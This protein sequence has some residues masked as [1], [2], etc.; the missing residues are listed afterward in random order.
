M[1]RRYF[2]YLLER[3]LSFFILP[4]D[5]AVEVEPRPSYKGVVLPEA[6]CVYRDS[7]RLEPGDL[8]I[9]DLKANPADYL[10]L[11]GNVHYENDIQV[12]LETL[13]PACSPSTRLVILY[14]SSLWKPLM[15]LATRLGLRGRAPEMNWV[16]PQDVQNLLCLAGYESVL[17]ESRVLCPVWIP[18]LSNL[19]NRWIAPLPG[20]RIFCL[21]RVSVARP[22]IDRNKAQPLPSVSIVVPARNEAGNIPSILQR[23]PAM[24]P[25]D[26]LILIE[27]HSKDE[28]WQAIQ[29]LIKTN[30]GRCIL[31]AQQ[32]GAG[33]GDAVRKGFALA[34]RDILVI[35]DADLTVAPEDLPKFYRAL[36]HGKGEFINGSRLVYPMEG[37]AMRFLNM[38][39]NKFFAAAFSFLLGQRFKDTLCGTKVLRRDNYLRLAAHRH[40]FG[41]FDPFGDFD[42]LFGAA[43]M[44]LKIMELPVAYRARTYGETNIDRWRHGWLLLRMVIFAARKLKFL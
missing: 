23:L 21:V 29:D 15:R 13:K 3:Y 11:N 41:D 5:N 36:V 27:G 17:D 10:I 24:G 25:D 4:G 7:A 37:E 12:F 40:Y 44:G 1:R 20:F 35:L 18:L 43:R 33:K 19:L 42:L 39:A 8:T 14:Y 34:S 30:P 2:H 32:D 22:L 26:E 6:R 31:A 38:V 16:A 9:D 28:T